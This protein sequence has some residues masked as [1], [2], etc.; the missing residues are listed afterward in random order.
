MRELGISYGRSCHAKIWTNDTISFVSLIDRLMD[1]VRTP[2]TVEEYRK[3]K[4]GREAEG[5]GQRRIR[6]RNTQGRQEERSERAVTLNA[7]SRCRQG[8]EG[9]P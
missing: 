9:V 6:R 4:G 2:E 1:P 7:H 5:E 3:L 8:H